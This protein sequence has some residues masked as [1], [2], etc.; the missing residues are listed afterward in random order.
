MDLQR[1]VMK[2]P[3]VTGEKDK[4]I[5]FVEGRFHASRCLLHGMAPTAKGSKHTMT[6][7]YYGSSLNRRL[8]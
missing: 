3:L 1:V 4:D 2:R 8:E 7:W 5:Q 6:T